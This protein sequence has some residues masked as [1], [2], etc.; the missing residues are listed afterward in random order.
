MTQTIQPLKPNWKIEDGYADHFK[1]RT[2]SEDNYT[3][4]KRFPLTE[5]EDRV[6]VLFPRAERKSHV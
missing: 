4:C 6:D 2:N 5:T 3:N 1:E